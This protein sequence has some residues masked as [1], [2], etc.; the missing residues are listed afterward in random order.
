M[1]HLA[2]NLK[3]YREHRGWTQVGM[4]AMLDIDRTT[5]SGYE[6]GTL[7]P[8][9]NMLLHIR[10]GCRLPLDQLLVHPMPKPKTMAMD[11]HLMKYQ[12]TG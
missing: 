4:A 12:F 5:Y 3:S 2:P 9:I 7:Q 10:E 11:A 8:S 1:N 6:N